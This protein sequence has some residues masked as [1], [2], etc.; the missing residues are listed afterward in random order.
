LGAS[1]FTTQVANATCEL[2]QVT[3]TYAR[4]GS[5]KDL[6]LCHQNDDAAWA[7]S[8]SG[9]VGHNLRR[10]NRPNAFVLQRERASVAHRSRF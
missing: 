1:V 9:L 8:A 5:A 2:H 3:S 4:N 10:F 6:G 7:G